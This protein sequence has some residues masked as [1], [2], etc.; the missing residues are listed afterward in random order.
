MSSFG[1]FPFPVVS[2]ASTCLLEIAHWFRLA[3]CVPDIICFPD[4]G[5]A[6]PQWLD[7][8]ATSRGIQSDLQLGVADR[9]DFKLEFLSVIADVFDSYI[10]NWE[11]SRFV[12]VNNKFG[13]APFLLLILKWN[14]SMSS[15]L[16]H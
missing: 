8:N 3:L 13:L 2:N 15:F 1:V 16:K 4:F 5:R 12:V 6:N 10:D 7:L 14:C 9:S 11:T